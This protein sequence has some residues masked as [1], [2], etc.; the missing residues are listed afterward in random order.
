MKT[1]KRLIKNYA[2]ICSVIALIS[3]QQSTPE[4]QVDSPKLELNNGE[5][6]EVNRAMKPLL[7]EMED[8]LHA[9][10]PRNGNYRE[11]AA[12][13]N[14]SNGD[15]LKICSVKNGSRE[16]LQQW[17][18]DWMAQLDNLT[19]ARSRGEANKAVSALKNGFETY[20]RHFQ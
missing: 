11:L 15:L 2:V 14:S 10:D 1:L 17:L 19:K 4:S 6:W 7:K 5:K 8:Q 13:L 20:H 9:Y 16:A 12:Q 3:C 18:M